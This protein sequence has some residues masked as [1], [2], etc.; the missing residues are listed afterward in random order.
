MAEPDTHTSRRKVA[1]GLRRVAVGSAL[2]VAFLISA[3]T[4]LACSASVQFGSDSPES[5]SRSVRAKH[6]GFSMDIPNDWLALN[7]DDQNPEAALKKFR[8]A[9]RLTG[10]GPFF[11]DDPASVVAAGVKLYAFK[12]NGSRSIGSE[13]LVQLLP[14]ISSL[15]REQDIRGG[16]AAGGMEPQGLETRE[17]TVAGVRTVEVS[18]RLDVGDRH[19]DKTG[20]LLLEPKG[21]LQIFFDTKDD[22]RK[23]KT[24]QTMIHSLKLLR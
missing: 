19:W 17:T 13:V 4:N 1:I 14:G 18:Y 12:P 11:T 16:L 20:Y 2:V 23:D 24:V 5:G 6:A 21:G 3:S 10:F 22:G 8:E 7:L 15:P 9:T